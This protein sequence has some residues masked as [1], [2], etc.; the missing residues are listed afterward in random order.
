MAIYL[1]L[2]MVVTQ[3]EYIKPCTFYI[4]GVHGFLM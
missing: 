1:M 2:K 4:G 3:K